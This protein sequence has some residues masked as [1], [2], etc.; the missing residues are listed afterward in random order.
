[1]VAR[2][3]NHGI[4]SEDEVKHKPVWI[5][6]KHTMTVLRLM[7][8]ETALMSAFI[9]SGLTGMMTSLILKYSAALWKAA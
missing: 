4:D 2:I 1:M 3:I 9:V 6:D 7:A 5:S 8:R